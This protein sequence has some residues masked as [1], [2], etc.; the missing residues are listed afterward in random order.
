MAKKVYWLSPVKNCDICNTPLVGKI[1]DGKTR[2]GPWALMC[3]SC[4]EL[5]G[6]GLGL[7]LGQKYEKQPDGKWLKIAG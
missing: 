5:D 1:V 4:H 3:V 7:G 6:C 2:M